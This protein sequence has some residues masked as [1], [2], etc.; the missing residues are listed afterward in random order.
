MWTSARQQTGNACYAQAYTSLPAPCP[1]MVLYLS[2]RQ[3][4]ALLRMTLARS[5]HAICL[6]VPP[7]SLLLLRLAELRPSGSSS[8]SSSSRM[9]GHAQFII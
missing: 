7:L 3:C 8:S 1:A 9:T 2:Y 5:M 6:A 4:C